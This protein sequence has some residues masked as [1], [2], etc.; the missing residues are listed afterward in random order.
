MSSQQ[1]SKIINSVDAEKSPLGVLGKGHPTG[2]EVMAKVPH[3]MSGHGIIAEAISNEGEGR[4]AVV[5]PVS[6]V[7]SHHEIQ[8]RNLGS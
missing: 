1:L 8:P 4:S 6:I 5:F 7:T 2:D 3:L